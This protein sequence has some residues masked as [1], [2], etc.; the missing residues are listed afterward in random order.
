MMPGDPE[1]HFMQ[2][3]LEEGIP[4][5]DRVWSELLKMADRYGV[6]MPE[7]VTA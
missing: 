6:A 4:V 5:D 2:Q 3:R 1:I 7:T